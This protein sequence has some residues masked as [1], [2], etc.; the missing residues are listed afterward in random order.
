MKIGF[1]FNHDH[2]HQIPHGAPIL[3]AL[4]Q[5]FPRVEIHAFVRAGPH[6]AFLKTL[7]PH[8]VSES[9]RW[10]ELR[11]SRLVRTM[12]RL[13]GQVAPLERMGALF[14]HRHEFAAMDALVVPETTSLMLK[15][16]PSCS[17]LKLIYTQH[18]AGDRAV[19]F[20][21]SIRHFDYVLVSGPKIQNR[22]LQAGLIRPNAYA[23]VGYP[24]FDVVNRTSAPR[25]F[26][27]NHPVVLYN[28]HCH[29][30]LS[31][32]FRDGLSVF[33]FFRT[34]PEYNLVFAPH[35]MLFAKRLHACAMPW[36]LQWRRSIPSRYRTSPNIR[37]DTTSTACVDRTYTRASDLYLG[38]VSSQIYE[39][40]QTPRPAIFLNSHRFA[41]QGDANFKHWSLGTVIEDVS[42]LGALLKD[43][44]WY[45]ERLRLRQE[46]AFTETFGDQVQGGGLRAAEAIADFV[47]SDS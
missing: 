24:K 15:R 38:D 30:H 12:G 25:L 10:H 39:F 6:L 4:A 8:A 45:D 46:Q 40:L 37:V 28:P 13:T 35:V 23:E 14:N 26:A 44:T 17:R 1:L 43:Q 32:W 2:L 21:P 33:E 34:H 11:T 3:A 16:L 27:N 22:M 20:K 36:R 47:F 42:A 41:W 7:L 5:A 18:G 19:G 9:V 29:P 31:S